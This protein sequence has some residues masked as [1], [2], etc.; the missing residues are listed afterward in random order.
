MKTTFFSLLIIITIIIASCKKKDVNEELQPTPPPVN[1]PT[2][3]GLL[4]YEPAFPP[5]DEPV[6][7]T[8][9]ATKGSSAL[10]DLAGDV[11]V[12]TGVITDK[13]TSPYD[14]KYVKSSEFNKPVEV[15]KLTNLGNNKFKFTLTPKQFYNVP[16]GENIL[17]LAMVFRN[18]DGSKEGKNTDRSDIYLPLYNKNELNVRFTNPESQPLYLAVPTVKIQMVGEELVVVAVA[19]KVSNLTLQLN[20]TNFGT[21][22]DA[23]KISATAKILTTGKQTLSVTAIAGGETKTSSFDFVIN[24]TVVTEALPAGATDGVTF[25]NGGKSAIFNLYAPGKQF[26]YLI[27][28]FNQWT[29]EPAY[30][31]KKT[32]DG[33]RFWVQVVNLDAGTEYAYQYQVDASLTI[34]DPYCQKVLDPWNDIFIPVSTYPNLKKYPTGKTSGIVSVMQYN[35]NPYPWKV[36]NFARPNKNKLVIYELHLRDFIAKANYITL[37]DTLDY[38]SNLGVNAIELMPFNEFEGN[39]SWGYNPSFYFAPDKYYGTKNNLKAFIDECHSRGIAVI[40]DMVLNHS[41]GQS[42]M[43]QLYFDAS[44][45]KPASNNPWFNPVATHPYSV[46]YDFN[47]ESQATQYFTKNVLKFWMQEYKID[48]YRFDLSKGFTQKNSGT[49]G[50]AVGPWGEYDASRIAIWKNYNDYMKSIDANNFYVILEH[51]AADAEEREL[52]AQGMMLWNNVNHNFIEGTMGFT[53]GSDLSRSIYTTHGFT[54]A[55]GLITYMESH[56]EERMMFKNLKYGNSAGSYSVKDVNT[57]L[58]RQELAAAFL[59]TTPGP[60]MIWQFGE[61]GYDISIDENGRTGKK[62]ILWNYKT[63]SQRKNL[64]AMFAKFIKLKT[65]N[66]IFNTSN[67]QHSLNGA[68]KTI[69]LKSADNNVVVV[70]N[71][72]V[73]DRT[74]NI[75]F[76]QNGQWIDFVSGSVINVSGTLSKT[77][78]PGQYYIYSSK[79]FN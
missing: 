71:F 44:V 6:T 73:V 65:K 32:P 17:K 77:L 58:K 63:I 27:G 18:A 76:P 56:D 45:G 75:E 3:T 4:T 35:P 38:L 46:G 61:L 8:Y 48:G 43:V 14:W 19:S 28:D 55:S 34:A 10:K 12:H 29:S 2:E 15:T 33:N 7:F 53:A 54:D 66:D 31:M 79:V 74:A 41:F 1:I 47:H 25:I 37:T 42:P 50:G 21:A 64:Y 26:A 59:F 68:V 20:G 40:M 70:G 16:A 49:D 51:F 22:N 60:K 24:G 52:A 9:D 5:A 30:F 11:F 62:P 23:V 67:I 13:S 78:A 69:T 36:N 57:A 72:D 39:D